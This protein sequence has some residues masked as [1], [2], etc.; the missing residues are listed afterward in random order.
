M[1]ERIRSQPSYDDLIGTIATLEHELEV[2]QEGFADI[3]LA[4]DDRGWALASHRL[5]EQLTRKGL[6]DIARNCRVMVVA[7]PLIKRG[8]QLRI[9]Y[10]WG[11]GVTVTARA[12]CHNPSRSLGSEAITA[13]SVVVLSATTRTPA[14][15]DRGMSGWTT[16]GL[17]RRVSAVDPSRTVSAVDRVVSDLQLF[18]N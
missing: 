13:G 16:L 5:E 11:Q 14:R 10:I 7:S 12:A 1:I 15:S 3:E 17:R 8:V 4:A 9:G 2:V 6:G 18:C